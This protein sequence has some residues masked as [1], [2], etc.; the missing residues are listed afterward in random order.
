MKK[1]VYFVVTICL[2]L[3]LAGCETYAG[4]KNY[5]N[6]TANRFISIPTQ[7]DLY[8]D[9]NTKIVYIMFSKKDGG[10]DCGVGYG[11]MS[12]YFANNGRP[13]LYEGGKLVKIDG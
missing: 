13:Y 7:Q 11:Y 9:I 12:P 10:G 3:C 2:M 5:S 4:D 8:Y 6:T 1:V